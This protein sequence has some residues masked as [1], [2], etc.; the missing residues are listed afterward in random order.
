[1]RPHAVQGAGGARPQATPMLGKC[2]IYFDFD[3]IDFDNLILMLL[4]II[5]I[6]V[7]YNTI[8]L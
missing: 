5:I 2:T 8:P 7:T 3:L 4:T 6:E 1:M